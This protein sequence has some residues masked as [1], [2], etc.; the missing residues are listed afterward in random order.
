MMA[1][2]NVPD[3][4]RDRFQEL[5]M[6]RKH[7]Y[8]I[9]KGNDDYSSVEIERVGERSEDMDSFK[10]N[11]PKDA[12]RYVFYVFTFIYSIILILPINTL[13]LFPT[14]FRW[15]VYDL[16]WKEDD[17]RKVGKILLIAY[18]P[19]ANTDATSKFVIPNSLG[20]LK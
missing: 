3:E 19:D 12:P 16:E 17:G 7:R 14:L 6:K 13:T 8:M 15:I 11:L 5:R 1:G 20:A 18:S 9:L 10:A 2:I 4:V